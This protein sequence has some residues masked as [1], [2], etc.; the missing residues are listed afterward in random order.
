MAVIAGVAVLTA[1]GVAVFF[2]R[3]S[4]GAPEAAPIAEAQNPAAA[5]TRV[6]ADVE[7]PIMTASLDPAFPVHKVVT[8]PVAALKGP[9][10][11]LPSPP[12]ARGKTAEPA[13][14]S[15]EIADAAEFDALEQQD[16]RWARAGADHS[17]AVFASVMQPGEGGA[18][19]ATGGTVPPGGGR[20]AARGDDA[21]DDTRTAAIAPDEAKPNAK[22]ETQS[23]DDA[24]AAEATR[25]V[26]IN[27][28]ANM[29]ARPKSG[30]STLTVVPRGAAVQLVGCKA[31]CEIIYKG[32]R[33]YIYKDFVGGSK[34]TASARSTR[35]T[36]AAAAKPKVKSVYVVDAAEKPAAAVEVEQQPAVQE[37]PKRFKFSSDRMQ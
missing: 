17:D 18:S 37:Q 36:K 32:Q 35:S 15:L 31:W 19:V 6:E 29:R 26:Q 5:D 10:L 7:K 33:G 22:S 25:T 23:K 8:K 1:G 20:P 34:R 4:Q 24:V 14:N 27:R 16:P 28:G 3:P 13:T 12:S 11:Q 9:A 21:A 2:A 30:S